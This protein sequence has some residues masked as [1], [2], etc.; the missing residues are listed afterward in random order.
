MKC[1]WEARDSKTLTL[2]KWALYDAINVY[3][4]TKNDQEPRESSKSPEFQVWYEFSEE[5][6]L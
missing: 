4:F 6:L 5:V 3:S 2:T 1:N